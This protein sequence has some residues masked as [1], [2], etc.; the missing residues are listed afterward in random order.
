MGFFAA[1]PGRFDGGL[2]NRSSIEAVPGRLGG[3]GGPPPGGPG[4]GGGPVDPGGV[5][6]ESSSAVIESA[7][8]DFA[9]L[10]PPS[11][12]SPRPVGAVDDLGMPGGGALPRPR[13]GGGGAA[14]KGRGPPLAS[15]RET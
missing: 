10:N 15:G 3:F 6:L 7:R 12:P 1:D 8:E 5:E 14:V 13:V 11:G 2:D 9:R 4:G